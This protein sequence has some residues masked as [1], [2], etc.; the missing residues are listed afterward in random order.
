MTATATAEFEAEL[1]D[2]LTR[3]L[4]CANRQCTDYGPELPVEWEVTYPGPRTLHGPNP[5]LICDRCFQR[6]IAYNG[7]VRSGA[8][9][10]HL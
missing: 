6:G 3:P 1:I 10:R 7:F 8:T 9:W 2:A 4:P 5:Y